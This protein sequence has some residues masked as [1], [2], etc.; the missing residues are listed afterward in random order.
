MHF[1]LNS[2]LFQNSTWAALCDSESSGPENSDKEQ[3][4]NSDNEKSCTSNEIIKPIKYKKRN[5]QK[6]ESQ[7]VIFYFP[8]NI[9]NFEQK[10]LIINY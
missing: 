9:F 5:I 1:F 2:F 10:I 8:R 6:D 7:E 3:A 4:Y